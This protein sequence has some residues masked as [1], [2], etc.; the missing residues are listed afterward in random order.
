VTENMVSPVCC[1][2]VWLVVRA[3]PT[4][5]MPGLKL[6]SSVLPVTTGALPMMYRS[7]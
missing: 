2:Q 1:D 7:A 5:S 3:P 4:T 6:L